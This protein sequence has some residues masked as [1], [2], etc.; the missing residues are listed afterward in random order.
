VDDD[1][2]SVLM[3]LRAWVMEH[4]DAQGMIDANVLDD[5]LA[6]LTGE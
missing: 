3:D 2:Y 5:H 1:T 6:E 4:M